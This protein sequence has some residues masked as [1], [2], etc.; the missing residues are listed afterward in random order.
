MVPADEEIAWLREHPDQS[1]ELPLPISIFIQALS[2]P[3]ASLFLNCTPFAGDERALFAHHTGAAWVLCQP[4]AQEAYQL[5]LL[6]DQADGLREIVR[7]VR[8]RHPFE[9][10]AMVLLPDHLHAIWQLPPGDV[11]Y[12]TR[13]ALVKAGFSRGIPKGERMSPSRAAKRERGIWQR[14]YWEH[15]IR[16]ERDLQAHVDYIHYNPVKHG[17][18]VRPSAWPHSSIH[19][20][21]RMGWLTEDW[22][23]SPGMPVVGG[24]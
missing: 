1:I 15:L 2:Q 18:V 5:T 6:T 20:H 21:I 16:D 4:L 13:W 19:R 7:A 10:V 9:I 12:A 3:R 24:E 22:A 11:D 8:L 17:Y 14:R 23:G